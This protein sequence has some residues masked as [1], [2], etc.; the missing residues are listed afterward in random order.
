MRAFISRRFGKSR[1]GLSLS[2]SEALI[3]TEFYIGTWAII[4]LIALG[5]WLA[6]G[7]PKSCTSTWDSQAQVWRERCSD[8]SRAVSRH[9]EQSRRLYTRDEVVPPR[10]R[11]K[12]QKG[13]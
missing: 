11:D 2:P 12:P 10:E 13:K 3:A 8:G 5:A 1:V 7:E 6:W 4:L 9:D